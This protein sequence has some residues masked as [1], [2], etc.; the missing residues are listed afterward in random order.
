MEAKAS[1]VSMG[2][3][4]GA[5]G[6]SAGPEVEHQATEDS[7]WAVKPNGIYPAVFQTYFGPIAPL[8][9]PISPFWSRNVY[10]RTVSFVCFESR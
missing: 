4:S 8:F 7:F 1:K 5:T 10:P 6:A 9:L 2:P 3:D